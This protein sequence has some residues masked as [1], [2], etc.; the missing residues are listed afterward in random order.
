M[1]GIREGINRYK[2]LNRLFQL[3]LGDLGMQLGMMN[4]SVGEINKI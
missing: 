2:L 1:G 3:W 4:A